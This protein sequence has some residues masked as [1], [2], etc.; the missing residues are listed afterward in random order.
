MEFAYVWSQDE[1]ETTA[2]E[3]VAVIVLFELPVVESG[4]DS[5]LTL[6]ERCV[7]VTHPQGRSTADDQDEEQGLHLRPG[8]G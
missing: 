5:P 6:T 1:T 4:V 3:P 2:G 8:S 7:Q